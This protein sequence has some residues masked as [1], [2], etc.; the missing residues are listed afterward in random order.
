MLVPQR[1]LR[2]VVSTDLV[3]QHIQRA[4]LVQLLVEEGLRRTHHKGRN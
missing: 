1:G 4:R 3:G 2:P